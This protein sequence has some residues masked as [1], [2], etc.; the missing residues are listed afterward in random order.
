M[1]KKT[2]L[3]EEHKRLGAKIVEFAGF[4]MPIQYGGV[5]EEH[6]AVR[7]NA[8]LFD[9]SHMGEFEFRGEESL[10]L[11]N[12]LTANDVAKLEDGKAQYSL[13][14]NEQGGIVDDILVYRLKPDHF[15]M[16][17]NASNIEKDFAWV[18]KHRANFQNVSLKNVSDQTALL[19]F[20]GPKTISIIK[21]L[22]TEK[23]EEL[24][25][26][27]FIVGTVA[28]QK[29]CWI[30]R[31]GYTGEDGVEIFCADEQATPLWQAILEKGGKPVGLGARDTL[32]LEARLSL[33][34]HE[35]TDETNPLE[36]GLSWVVKLDKKDFI[37]KKA[38]DEIK[39]KGLA[40]TLIGF[41]MIDQGIARQGFAII[42][43]G[44]NVGFVTSGTFSPTLKIAIGLGYVPLA[45]SPIGSKFNIDIRGKQKLAEVVSVPFYKR[46]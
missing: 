44:K 2:S 15:L 1:T 45:L 25:P 4:E 13:L 6:N 30:A 20:Q 12:Y 33:Y 36:A 35:I 18:S 21:T 23:I 17:V 28:G 39:A 42:A 43:D 37:G 9:V 38:L 11:L 22:T 46:S 34:G 31:T 27:R 5:V 32:R 41:K 16:V 24:K 7:Q 10:A 26:F 3:Y 14:L 40:R 19:A 29:N 8:G